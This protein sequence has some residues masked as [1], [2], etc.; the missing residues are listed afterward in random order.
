M[1]KK[2]IL[3]VLIAC[4]SAV[5]LCGSSAFAGG[6]GALEPKIDI[7]TVVL[8]NGQSS[9]VTA[10]LTG[11]FDFEIV[12]VTLIGNG[13]FSAN[14]SRTNTTGEIVFVMLQG[15]GVPSFDL[16]FGITPV[17]IRASSTISEEDDYAFGVVI[18]GILFSGEEAPYEYS[19]SLS[20]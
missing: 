18:H 9:S 14:L 5:F 15:F 6:L 19:V 7:D 4:V 2:L 12:P 13:S 11:P 20:Y 1:K 16:N 17:S 8:L 3:T 10:D